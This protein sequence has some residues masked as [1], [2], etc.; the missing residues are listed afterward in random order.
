MT[1]TVRRT[2]QPDDLITDLVTRFQAGARIGALAMDTGHRR[3]AIRHL[4]TDAG[5]RSQHPAWIGADTDTITVAM[6]TRRRQGASM[7]ILSYDTGIG[8]RPLTRMLIAA[9]Y[10]PAHGS[11]IPSDELPWLIQ[12]IQAG[13]TVQELAEES[14][15]PRTTLYQTLV[16]HGALSP[17]TRTADSTDSS[18]LSWVEQA[19]AEGRYREAC[20]L[21]LDLWIL[22]ARCPTARATTEWRTRLSAAGEQGARRAALR[23]DLGWLHHL[24]ARVAADVG[25]YTTAEAQWRAALTVWRALAA[26][27]QMISTL[28]AL[29]GLY[30]ATGQ[31]HHAQNT[32]SYLVRVCR[33]VDDRA[34][35]ARGWDGLAATMDALHQ[36]DVAALYR[37]CA[38]RTRNQIHASLADTYGAHPST[39]R[40]PG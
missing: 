32:G 6:T 7:E 40:Y 16:R 15:Y 17:R 34:G 2:G 21:A 36:P 14:G 5:V 19:V 37:H 20:T 4:L 26:P 33:Q 25:D 13:T 22:T 9:G 28:D 8:T 11:P 30:R 27:H 39:W 31:L 29:T 1:A 10:P 35:E 18:W 3:D 38:Q 12:C 24:S 23:A